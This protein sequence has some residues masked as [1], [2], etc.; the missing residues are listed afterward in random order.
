MNDREFE[1]LVG[2]IRR[3]R[4]LPL[5]PKESQFVGDGDF[6]AIG[7]EFL[8]HS[9]RLG[10]LR[11][12]ANVLDLGCG[13]GRLALPLTQ[14]LT[15]EAGYIGVDVH[16]EG[17]EWCRRM[18]CPAYRNFR[19]IRLDIRHPIYNP[20]G[21]LDGATLELPFPDHT[22]DF[23]AAISLFTH[24]GEAEVMNYA[25]EIRRI[26]RPEGRCMATFF[27][28]NE[29]AR[30]GL[31]AEPARLPFDVQSDSFQ[32]EAFPQNPGA[33]VAFEE[34]GLLERLRAAGLAPAIPVAHGTWSGRRTGL[35]YQDLCVLQPVPAARS[36]ARRRSARASAA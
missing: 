12:S 13:I 21:A 35:T 16:P 8:E 10:A 17:I 2:L 18:I 23:V 4:F 27:L 36:A 15:P 3:N 29:G 33:A 32:L 20:G 34:T 31:R 24:L 9:V 6:L 11:P 25:R 22:F 30:E 19:F 14:F 1:I 28:L 5:P 7:M 26:L